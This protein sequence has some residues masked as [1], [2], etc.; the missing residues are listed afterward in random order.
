MP[1]DPSVSSPAA[2]RQTAVVLLTAALALTLQEYFFNFGNLAW[3]ID[4]LAA[5]GWNEQADHWRDWVNQS[6]NFEIA[7]LSWWAVGRVLTYVL[8]PLLVIKLVL[9]QPLPEMGLRVRGI[10]GGLPLYLLLL[11]LILPAV[12]YFSRTAHFQ[13]TYPFY[14]LSAGEALWPRFWIWE[15]LY[16]VQ[17]V[18]LEFF[19]RGFMIHGTKHALGRSAIYVMM[20]PYVMLHFTKPMPETLGA[21]GAGV[22]LGHLS[23]KT[24]SI[25]WGAALHIAVAWTMDFLALSHRGLL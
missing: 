16:A 3:C 7:R 17:F 11:A 23:Y 15:L 19:F 1:G 21:I 25:W 9:R 4:R 10:G 22:I 13:R 14:S 6:E 24:C 5:L 2:D 12:W 18:A 8:L 20:L